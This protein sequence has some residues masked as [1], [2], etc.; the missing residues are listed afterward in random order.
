MGSVQTPFSSLNSTLI[1]PFP[2][3]NVF[4]PYRNPKFHATPFPPVP[5]ETF[6]LPHAYAKNAPGSVVM[7][8]G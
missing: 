6:P 1:L 8:G 4:A 2:L 5:R 7:W 3:P